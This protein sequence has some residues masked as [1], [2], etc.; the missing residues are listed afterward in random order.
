MKPFRSFLLILLLATPHLAHTAPQFGY[1][2]K[3]HVSELRH[4]GY[5][6]IIAG[7]G[8]SGLT[9]ADRL[10]E[11]FPN[12]S[13]LVVEYGDIEYAPGVWDPPKTAW[14]DTSGMSSRWALNSLPSP[15]LNNQ[16]AAVIV[17]QSV[18]GSS[19][20]NGMFFD[21]GSRFD[22]DAW[23]DLQ[24][25]DG[26]RDAVGWDWSGIYTYFK[27]SVT[28]TPPPISVANQLNYTWDKSVF[29]NTTPIHASFPPF[30]WGDHYAVRQAWL[31]MGIRLAKEC[32]TG[33]K[34]GVCWIPIS[35]H[36]ISARRSYSGVG[37]YSDVV[38]SRSNYH[39]LV[40][41]Q[42]TQ[43]IYAHGDVEAGP[44]LLEIK[45]LVD[46]QASNLTA[47]AEVILAAGVFGTPA[48]LQRSG[49]G[50]AA[51]LRRAN[52][53]VVHDLPGV[54]AN[55]QDHSGPQ[56]AWKYTSPPPFSP[57]PTDMLD[58]VYATRAAADF[59][60]TPATGPYTLAMSNTAI[61][62][63]LS[64]ITAHYSD[65]MQQ[66]RNLA[67]VSEPESLHLPPEYE[68]DATL[69]AGYRAQLLALANML[70]N[71]RAPSLESAFTTGT[72]VSAVLLHPLSRGTVRLNLSRPLDPPI[73][74]YRSASNHL[75]VVLHL[76]HLKYLR[77]TVQAPTLQGLGAVEIQPGIRRQTDEDL[78]AYIRNT[79]VQSYMHPCCTSAM[80]PLAKGGVVGVDL[81]VHG[82][83][84]LRVVDAGIFPMLP[85][86][87]LSATVYAVAEK[88][89]DIII[90]HWS[91]G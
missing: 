8:T 48:I 76:H 59:D 25:D 91:R 12:K 14:G 29:G 70:S 83:A 90:T 6:F 33:D 60:A 24:T 56:V 69:A 2:A 40:K 63:P 31:E 16:G 67:N 57:M 50:P 21:R 54:G 73:L 35:Q 18:G 7:G 36:P 51:F 88:A 80:L 34:E 78:V 53:E 81:R 68:S 79:T 58:P 61:W 39:L 72:A 22:Y 23:S 43:V 38:G 26:R 45:S 84:G 49:I 71:P 86:A 74:N 42:V 64:N 85:S 32:A 5:D 55:L 13:I 82:V 62:V 41:H 4:D 1:A 28:F 47:A 87:H 75:D 52:I 77:R 15:S 20:T 46:G 17:G 19:A 44:P 11:A 30:Q 65:L 10:S 66:I 27:K 9:V 37:H 3:R 89:A